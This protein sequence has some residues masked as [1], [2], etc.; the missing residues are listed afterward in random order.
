MEN[1]VST[2]PKVRITPEEYLEL[3]RRSETKHE[4]LN[5]EVFAMPGVTRQ[6]NLIAVNITVELGMQVID[7]PCEVY[8]ID[9]R[10]KVRPTGLYTY[11]DIAVVCGAPEFEDEREDTLLNPQVIIE[12]LSDSTE[13]Y[14]RGRKFA[15]YRAVESLREYLLVSQA[16]CRVERFAR[17]DDS[18]WIYAETTDPNGAVEL[19]SVACRLTLSRVYHRIGF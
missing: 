5:G 15:H 2:Q 16:E 19:T 4:Y 1:N 10:T 6:H 9:L 12:V 7:R 3:E 8:A 11:P 13:S 17:Q 18:S 14:D